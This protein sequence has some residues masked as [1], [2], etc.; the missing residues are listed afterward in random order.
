MAST[1]RHVKEPLEYVRCGDCGATMPAG[2][3][4]CDHCGHAL[5]PPPSAPPPDGP[6]LGPAS[7]PPPPLPPPPFPP[8]APRDTM[9]TT[10]A[11]AGE[12][13][14]RGHRRRRVIIG[15]ATALVVLALAGTGVVLLGREAPEVEPVSVSV[16]ELMAGDC[17]LTPSAHTEPA[18][19]QLQFWQDR[20]GFL[21]T[22]DVVPCEQVHGA[23]VYFV[24]EIWAADAAYPGDA[25]VDDAWWS[26]C[27]REFRT[28]A[29]VAPGRAGFEL[30]GWL[31][32]ASTWVRGDREITCLAYDAAGEDLRGTVAERTSAGG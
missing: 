12:P 18:S 28:Y 26:S 14:A 9:P 31:P 1:D 24:G 32:D 6:P 19:R 16:F 29:G 30:N 4:F 21:S 8:P 27:E 11:P 7:G 5:R 22:F 15:A 2:S 20:F 3:A 23:E 10:G 25:A 13:R 17:L